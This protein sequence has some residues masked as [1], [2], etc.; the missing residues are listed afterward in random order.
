MSFTVMRVTNKLGISISPRTVSLRP[1][2]LRLF[3][4]NN[5]DDIKR[6]ITTKIEV[7]AEEED[8]Q[9]NVLASPKPS[10][11]LQ[12]IYQRGLPGTLQHR[13]PQVIS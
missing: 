7:W 10:G 4:S 8:P 3:I 6:R 1:A 12:G 5:P 11:T 9:T 2:Q 13:L